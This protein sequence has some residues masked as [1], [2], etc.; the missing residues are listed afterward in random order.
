MRSHVCSISEVAGG[1][2]CV[3]EMLPERAEMVGGG[4]PAAV[5]C[6]L[7]ATGGRLA[8]SGAAVDGEGC[9][10][11]FSSGAAFWLFIICLRR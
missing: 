6:A 10:G 3:F 7:L 2:L 8:P 5:G 1:S 9:I 11:D 4:A